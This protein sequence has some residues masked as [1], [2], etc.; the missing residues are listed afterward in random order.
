MHFFKTESKWKWSPC[1]HEASYVQLQ[2]L[3][4]KWLIW[5]NHALAPQ[6]GFQT[7]RCWYFCPL[8]K[9]LYN[10]CVQDCWVKIC[11]IHFFWE[12]AQN[13]FCNCIIHYRL[14]NKHWKFV[15]KTQSE[16]ETT[17]TSKQALRYKTKW[18]D[19][20]WCHLLFSAP[21]VKPHWGVI[22]VAFLLCK[23]LN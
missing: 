13:I 9:C 23:F 5:L 21:S 1:M 18:Y 20:D 17:P 3:F 11:V 7:L 2:Y 8:K 15:S 16:H 4:S 12:A 6:L 14:Q 10:A 22:N 19:I